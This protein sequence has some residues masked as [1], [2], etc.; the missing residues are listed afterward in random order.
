MGGKRHATRE[1]RHGHGGRNDS[2]VSQM[3]GGLGMPGFGSF[4]D[5]LFAPP[6]RSHYPSAAELIQMRRDPNHP[7]HQHNR[8]QHNGG[9][10]PSMLNQIIND[11]MGPMTNH[12]PRV[13][14]VKRQPP[15]VIRIRMPI[16]NVIR[17]PP[18]PGYQ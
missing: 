4:L 11:L 18:L 10:P 9:A 17:G 13:F 14:R 12:M 7:R 2:M 16:H 15:K 1:T 6:K 5:D 8:P 3:L